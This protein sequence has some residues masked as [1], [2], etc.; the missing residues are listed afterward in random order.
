MADSRDTGDSWQQAAGS[1]QPTT[2]LV[3]R[4]VAKYVNLRQTRKQRG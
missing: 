4:G 3:G 2:E 1:R